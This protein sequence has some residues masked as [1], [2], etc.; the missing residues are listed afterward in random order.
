MTRTTTHTER[1]DQAMLWASQLHRTQRRK[2]KDIPY[3]SHLLSVSALVW[4]DGGSEDQAIAALLHDAIED[5]G[6][7]EATITDRF[8]SAVAQIVVACKIGRAHV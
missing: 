7:D 6:Q 4:E 1:Y 5:A 8:G 3:L 2:G